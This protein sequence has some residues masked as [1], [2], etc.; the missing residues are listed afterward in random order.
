MCHTEHELVQVLSFLAGSWMKA[1]TPLISQATFIYLQLGIVVYVIT[2]SSFFTSLICL[3]QINGQVNKVVQSCMTTATDQ[4]REYIRSRVRITYAYLFHS[5]PA[6]S[7]QNSSAFCAANQLPCV[8]EKIA[9]M[10]MLKNIGTPTYL[11]DQPLYK[12]MLVFIRL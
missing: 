1:E 3:I 2:M 7:A 4:L 10:R 11:L 6:E 5:L 12:V 8:S 9:I